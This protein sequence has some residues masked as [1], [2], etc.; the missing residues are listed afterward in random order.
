[1]FES[2][3]TCLYTWNW[4]AKFKLLLHRS[5]QNDVKMREMIK[6]IL[7]GAQTCEFIPTVLWTRTREGSLERTTSLITTWDDGIT[8]STFNSAHFQ[9]I[10]FRRTLSISV[11]ALRHNWPFWLISDTVPLVTLLGY[12]IGILLENISRIFLILLC[13]F[14]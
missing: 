13:I 2:K 9:G 4:E 12:F 14:V 11:I 6:V 5:C 1:M 3:V 10:M 8:G 7:A